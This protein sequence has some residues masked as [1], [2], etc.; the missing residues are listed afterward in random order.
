MQRSGEKVTAGRGN[1]KCQGPEAGKVSAL[2]EQR[3]AGRGG[4][5]VNEA[6]KP[7]S[8]YFLQTVERSLGF[9]ASHIETSL[10]FCHYFFF[11]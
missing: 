9:F 1:S 11:F 3:D 8:Y 10:A 4:R 7:G 6:E 5:K 2:V